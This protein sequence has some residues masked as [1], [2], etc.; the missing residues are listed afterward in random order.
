MGTLSKT[1]SNHVTSL[2]KTTFWLHT[3]FTTNPKL[4]NITHEAKKATIP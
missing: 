3:A 4:C 2:L 1:E